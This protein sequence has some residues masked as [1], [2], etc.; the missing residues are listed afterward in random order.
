MNR[1]AFLQ[2]TAGT[3]LCFPAVITSS[4]S[5]RK[6]YDLLITGGIVYDGLGNPGIH[7]DVAI[8]R[9]RVVAIAPGIPTNKASEVIEAKGLAVAPGFVDPHTHTDIQLLIN[10]KAE[11]KIRQGVTSEIGGNCGGSQFPLTEKSFEG[12]AGYFSQEFDVELTWRDVTGFFSRLEETGMALNY[13]TLLGHGSLRSFVMG[14]YDRPPTEEELTLM[15][16]LITENMRAG[17]LGMSTGLIYP[18][19]SFAR[20]DELVELCRTVSR[21]G[22]VHAS[23]IRGEAETV[24]D[25]VDEVLAISRESGASLQV[26]HIKAMNPGN[27]D[28]IDDVL[29][30]VERGKRDN[31]NVMADRYPYSA[32]STGLASFFPQW[33]R[34][35]GTEDFIARLRD[36]TLDPKLRS[37]LK[38]REEQTGSWENVLISSVHTDKNNVLVGKTVLQAAK[39]NEKSPFD[40]MRD[41]LIEEEGHV[42]VVKFVMSEDNLKQV[43][44]HPLVMIGSDGNVLAPYGQLSKGQPHPRSYGTFPRVLGKYVREEGVLTLPDAIKKMTSMAAGKFG[45]TGR[46]Q[47]MVGAFADITV[48]NP[49]TVIDRATFS[50]PHQYPT[51]IEYVIVNGTTVIAGGDHTGNLP[52]KVLKH[53][54][55]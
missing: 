26:S 33:A 29:S 31:L 7:A 47:L 28:K 30:S 44:A 10:P 11:S 8:S 37:Y 55:T 52:G 50:N 22:G 6:D 40:F 36:M 48:F 12:K 32:S 49:D 18:P 39:E 2:H 43:L 16:Q 42:A 15:R 46:G 13:A 51:G 17:V 34:E 19:S 41:L 27:W 38:M 1:R 45:L 5:A 54:A 23:H 20:I 25:A 35:G 21:F 14:P 3:A 4:C 24:L 53:T 9:D